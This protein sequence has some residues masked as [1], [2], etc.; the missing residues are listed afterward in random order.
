[1]RRMVLKSSYL[2]HYF[3]QKQ[4]IKNWKEAGEEFGE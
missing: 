2:N 1:V 3:F 4:L